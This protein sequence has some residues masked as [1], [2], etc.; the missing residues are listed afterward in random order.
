M[1]LN[2]Q[3]VDSLRRVFQNGFRAIDLAEPLISFDATTPVD[4]MIAGMES[5]NADLAGIRHNGKVTAFVLKEDLR[6][7]AGQNSLHSIC[8]STIL[9]DT[10]SLV[11]VVLGLRDH[12]QLFLSVLGQVCAVVTREDLQKPAARMW[13]FGM[14]TLIEMRTSRLIERF[15]ENEEW[16]EFISEGRIEKSKAIQAERSRR[17]R[18]VRLLD[19]LQL[20]DKLQI[21]S[22]SETL[23]KQTRFESRRQMEQATKALEKLRNNLAHSQ[24]FIGTDWNA[25]AGLAENFDKVI[26]GPPGLSDELTATN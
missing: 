6:A 16:Q 4:Q 10:A 13:L 24:D 1:S 12:N 9:P 8:E 2:S 17:N 22:R 21:V 26:S 7:D 18:E 3:D 25:I 23:R 11:D 15:C 14:I 19:C 5:G 20:S